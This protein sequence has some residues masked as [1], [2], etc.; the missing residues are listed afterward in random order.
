MPLLEAY[1][2]H[3]GSSPRQTLLLQTKLSYGKEAERI[4]LD[5]LADSSLLGS[6]VAL[7]AAPSVVFLP[8]MVP[9]RGKPAHLHPLQTHT[10]G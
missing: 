8:K 6:T 3:L 10:H 4:L 9:S 5:F 1:H 2:Q 7:A